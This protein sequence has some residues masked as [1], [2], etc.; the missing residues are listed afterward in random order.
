MGLFDIQLFWKTDCV[1]RFTEFRPK[2][3]VSHYKAAKI[4]F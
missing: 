3:F 4:L 2:K 1:Q